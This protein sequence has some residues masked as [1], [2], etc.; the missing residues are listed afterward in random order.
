MPEIYLKAVASCVGS[1]TEVNDVAT[2]QQDAQELERIVG[3]TGVRQRPVAAEDELTSTLAARAARQ[4]IGTGACDAGS[5][6]A[7][8]VC[9]QTPDHLIPGVSSRVHG[10]LGLQ[11]PCIAVDLNQ[12]CSGFIYGLQLTAGMLHSRAAETA[13]LINADCYSKLIRPNDYTT[14][15][16]F[17]DAAA[18]SLLSTKEGGLRLDYLRCYSDGRGY[19]AF[20]ARNSAIQADAEPRGIHMDGPGILNFALREVPEA[21]EHALVA[22]GLRREDIRFFAF[23]QANSFVLSKLRH[24]LGLSTAQ[25]PDHC[26]E[27]GNTVSA[28]IPLVLQTLWAELQPGDKLLA[29]GFGV[30]LSWGTALF[31]YTRSSA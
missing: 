11:K 27:L 17:G 31:E 20:V 7:L 19:E 4:L 18:A 10:L 22:M 1:H 23:H 14:R 12:G 21:V 26:A 8:L 6:N 13:L 3:K 9:T 30:G 24:K 5:I 2:L 28:S 16:L 25:V 15:V 29:V